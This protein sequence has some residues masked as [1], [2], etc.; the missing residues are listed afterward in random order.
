MENSRY[1][2][3]IDIENEYQANRFV[4]YLEE[5]I[6]FYY[7]CPNI[8]ILFSVKS[9]DGNYIVLEELS[10]YESYARDLLHRCLFTSPPPFK[11]TCKVRVVTKVIVL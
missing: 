5:L 6:S 8:D 3:N 9:E 2:T 1:C 7:L 11:I 4:K 10:I